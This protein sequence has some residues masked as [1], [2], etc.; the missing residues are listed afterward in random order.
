MA[1]VVDTMSA[2]VLGR[3]RSLTSRPGLCDRRG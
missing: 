3:A 2:A 1:R